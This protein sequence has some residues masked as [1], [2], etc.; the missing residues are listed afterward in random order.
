MA[1]TLEDKKKIVSEV[2]AVASD[3]HSAGAAE[4]HGLSVGEMTEL[5]VKAREGGVYLRV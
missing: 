1:L 4:Y 2:A 3:A 5:R